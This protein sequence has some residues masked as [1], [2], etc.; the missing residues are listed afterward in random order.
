MKDLKYLYEFEKLLESANNP[1][2]QQACAEGKHALAYTC[3][4]MPEVLLNT[5][6]CFSV[7][8]RAPLTGSLDISSYYM[9]NF[10]CDYCKS[11]LERGIEGGYNFLSALLATETCS[12]MNRALEHFELLHLVDNEQFFVTFLDM[13]FKVTDNT[14][15]HYVDQLRRKVLEPLHEVYG[16]DVSDDALRKAVAEHNEVCSIISEMGEMRKAD[17]PVI[18]GYEFHVINLVS[19]T[20]PKRLILPY[21][22]ETLA[23]LKK[24]KPD[25]VSPFRARVAI[26]GSEIDDPDLT[27]LI[28]GCGALVVSDRFCFGSTPGREVIELKDDE[29]ALR[30]ICLH[31]MEHS[32]CARYIAD[33]KVLQRRETADRLAKEYKAEGIIYEQMKYCDYWGFERALASHIMHDEYGWPVLSIDRLYNNGNSGQLRTRVQAFVESLEIKRIHKEEG[34]A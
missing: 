21:L 11:L 26:V 33:E 19:Y 4:H 25:K 28:E 7:R 5:G 8:L 14:V 31:V 15:R 18:T 10:I 9:S 30:Q 27:K 17:N 1:L 12:E 6:D 3:Y 2:V 32:E 24:R 29:D 20:C 13:P 22:R 16:V 23:E 34:K